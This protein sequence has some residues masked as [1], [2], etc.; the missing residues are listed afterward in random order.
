MTEHDATEVAYNNG[1]EAGKPKWIPVSE[2]L[3]AKYVGVL[4]HTP[5][6]YPLPT[7]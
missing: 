2:G 1:K 3:P 4:I 6:E 5:L 7:V